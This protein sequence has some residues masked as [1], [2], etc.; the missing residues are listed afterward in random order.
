MALHDEV[1]ALAWAAAPALPRRLPRC[2]IGC[3]TK[4][5]LTMTPADGDPLIGMETGISL[6]ETFACHHLSAGWKSGLQ[7]RQMPTTYHLGGQ[8]GPTIHVDDA[9]SGGQ[10]Q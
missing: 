1:Y 8:R 10:R 2:F 7:Q 3:S 6:I 5:D 9:H 4:N